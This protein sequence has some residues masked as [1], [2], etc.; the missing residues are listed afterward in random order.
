M[1]KLSQN[2]SL[3]PAVERL[4]FVDPQER[5]KQY[6]L[7]LDS[8]FN[9]LL[10]GNRAF[11]LIKLFTPPE[12]LVHNGGLPFDFHSKWDTFTAEVRRATALD[13]SKQEAILA[14]NHAASETV[15]DDSIYVDSIEV[16][17]NGGI[18]EPLI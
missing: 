7:T 12:F 5:R 4:V 2:A 16:S 9:K 10:N 3:P 6:D 8:A 15:L 18:L 1:E 14:A 17:R 11:E 13:V